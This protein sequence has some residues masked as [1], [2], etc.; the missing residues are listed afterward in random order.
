MDD[1]HFGYKQKLFKKNT[2]YTKWSL[3]YGQHEQCHSPIV[4]VVVVVGIKEFIAWTEHE[5]CKFWDGALD[6]RVLVSA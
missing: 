1:S 3:T 2:G 4:V 5:W 6:C